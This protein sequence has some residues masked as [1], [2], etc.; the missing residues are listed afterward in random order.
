MYDNNNVSL[1]H[2][3]IVYMKPNRKRMKNEYYC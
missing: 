3:E 2:T 1:Q